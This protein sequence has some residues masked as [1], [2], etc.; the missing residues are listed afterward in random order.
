[1]KEDWAAAHAWCRK[2]AAQ[3]H[4]IGLL[5]VGRQYQFG[6]GVQQDRQAAIRWFELAEDQG[7][8]TAAFLAR[9]LAQ[10]GSCLGYLTHEERKKYAGVCADPA[11]LFRTSGERTAWL[12]EALRTARV[13]SFNS[14]G[15]ESGLCRGRGMD[16]SGGS[17]QG[18]GGRPLDPYGNQDRYGRS[19]W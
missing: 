15:Y 12:N 1:M 10:P 4:A 16:Y 5:C 14:G 13:D 9:H 17:C 2:S 3:Q 7:D 11:R 19:P 8:G 18:E 6:L